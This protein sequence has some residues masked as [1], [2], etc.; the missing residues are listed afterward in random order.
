MNML[1]TFNKSVRHL[2]RR[3]G[4]K[5]MA[6]KV[7]MTGRHVIVTGASPNSL[8]YETARL[9]AGWGASV[10]ATSTRHVAR[11][12]SALKE[13]LRRI[14]ANGNNVTARPLDLSDVDSVNRFTTWYRN[15]HNGKLHVLV[16]NAGIHKNILKP[17]TRPPLSKDGFEIH[18]RINY[19]GTC[20]L[21]S[22]LLPL[23]KQGG[24]ES[25][26]ARLVNVSSH[27]HDRVTNADL[28]DANRRYHSWDAYGLSKL[29]LVHHAYEIER[30]FAKQYNLHS[31]ALHPGSVDTNLTRMEAP[32]GKTGKV[33][34][35][36]SSA[37]ASLV[38]LPLKDGAQTIVM[39]A[40]KHPLQGGGYYD[41]CSL[42]ESSDES[43]DETVSKLL[44]D[45]SEAWVA[46]LVKP[47]GVEH[48]QV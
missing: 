19:L 10:V 5:P 14:G 29:A 32:Q 18:W 44:W 46:G 23:L 34:H 24:L 42:A 45:K 41:R 22:L 7:D 11:M 21:T 30:R 36:I 2:W 35:R 43:K 6:E 1:H 48:E 39:C 4:R 3:F 17:H 25:G 15:S 47:D 38:L 37:L 28:F 40:S 13:D 20:H 31:V 33:L 12:E 9:L 26:D 16:N 8:G 27:L